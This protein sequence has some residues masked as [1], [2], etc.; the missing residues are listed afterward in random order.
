MDAGQHSRKMLSVH[1]MMSLAILSG[2]PVI[3][4]IASVL[5]LSNDYV[6]MQRL[7]MGVRE[8]GTWRLAIVCCS[9]RATQPL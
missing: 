4:F 9:W 2:E 5:H 7:R 8:Y 6:F 3:V 1:H